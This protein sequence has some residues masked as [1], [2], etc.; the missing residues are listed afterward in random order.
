MTD[1]SGG[2][3]IKRLRM[4]QAIVA[5]GSITAAAEALGVA[6]PAVSAHLRDLEL[7]LG[8]PLFVRQ[9]RGVLPT[10]AG[11]IVAEHA[12]TILRRVATIGEDVRGLVTEPRGRVRLGLP[13]SVAV[14]LVRP[15]I[16]RLAS[17]HPRIDL[18]IEELFSGTMGQRLADHRLDLAV[19]VGRPPQSGVEAVPFLRERMY[20]VCPADGGPSADA[21]TFGDLARLPLIL[22]SRHHGVRSLL[23]SHALT[24]SMHLEVRYEIDSAYQLIALVEAGLGV[25]VLTRS[26]IKEG[27]DRGR[28]VAVPITDPD[29]E[30]DICLAMHRD[31]RLE[32][33]VDIIRDLIFDLSA[34]AIADGSWDAE[35]LAPPRPRR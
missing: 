5:T 16:E 17:A 25:T 26:A 9:S 23:E 2:I 6:Q 12:E 10:E 33:A 24:R 3:D 18:A 21:V 14:V 27:L 34:A 19:T 4:V 28:L 29:L 13:F 31:R 30:R 35:W 22:P 15:I 20:L 11:R 8:T 7:S 1:V 32:R